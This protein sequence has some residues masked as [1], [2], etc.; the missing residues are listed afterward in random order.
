MRSPG[1]AVESIVSSWI[2]DKRK[3]KRGEKQSRA[4]ARRYALWPSN[5]NYKLANL[6]AM[7]VQSS[8]LWLLLGPKLPNSWWWEFTPPIAVA[9]F[10]VPVKCMKIQTSGINNGLSLSTCRSAGIWQGPQITFDDLH[11]MIKYTNSSDKKYPIS[12]RGNY[13][14]NL[15]IVCLQILLCHQASMP[16]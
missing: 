11:C 9:A 7:E 5:R 12:A 1:S 6:W 16:P 15:A 10:G 4:F 3:N 8:S 14:R 2:V 13:A